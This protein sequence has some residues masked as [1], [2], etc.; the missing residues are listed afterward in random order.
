LSQAVF[1][2]ILQVRGRV[3]VC[4]FRVKIAAAGSLDRRGLRK[5]YEN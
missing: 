4:N 1:G 3:P 2:M 5:H